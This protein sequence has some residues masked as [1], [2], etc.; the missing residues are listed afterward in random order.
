M[1]RAFGLASYGMAM[2]LMGPI[3]TLTVMP[4]YLLMGRLYDSSGSYQLG[5]T[6]FAG[7]AVVSALLLVPLKLDGDK[8]LSN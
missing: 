7:L 8:S 3:I 1:A 4:G 5:M 2:G 6:V